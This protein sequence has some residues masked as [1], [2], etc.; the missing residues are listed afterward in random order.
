MELGLGQLPTEPRA[1]WQQ[2][3]S[4]DLKSESG[5]AVPANLVQCTEVCTD[6]AGGI[7][8]QKILQNK[9]VK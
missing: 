6:T 3:V 1:T 7:Q 2:A 5:R 8:I 9:D 4:E